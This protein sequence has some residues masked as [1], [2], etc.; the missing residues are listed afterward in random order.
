M[1][2]IAG[3]IPI[4]DR[5]DQFLGLIYLILDA[6][7]AVVCQFYYSPAGLRKT[8]QHPLFGDNLCIAFD[9]GRSAH[10]LHYFVKIDPSAAVF[11]FAVRFQI[12]GHRDQ[13]DSVAALVK[14]GHSQVYFLVLLKIKILRT[15][16]NL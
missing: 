12:F 14:G 4:P 13:I 3:I 15:G 1:R 2:Q 6:D 7:I 11:Q 16:N 5:K 10:A 8:A 9:V